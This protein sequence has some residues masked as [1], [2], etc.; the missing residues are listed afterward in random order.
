MVHGQTSACVMAKSSGHR[1]GPNSGM[2]EHSTMPLFLAQDRTW[3]T[4]H[5]PYRS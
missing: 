2:V 3:D 1:K 4:Q 5:I